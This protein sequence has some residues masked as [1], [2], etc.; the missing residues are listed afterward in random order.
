MADP[1]T[2]VGATA[3]VVQLIEFTSKVL[4]R[5]NEY[6]AKAGELP[7][8]F[9]H[10]AS[11]LPLLRQILEKTQEGINLQTISHEDAEAI[12]PC[13]QG[14]Q[15]QMQKLDTLLLTMLPEAQDRTAKKLAKGLRSLWKDS[16]V[17]KIGAEIDF[18]VA[19]LNFYCSWSSSKLDPRNQDL[20]VTIQQRLAPPDP[21][22]N[23]HK[24]LKL[25]SAKTG[26]WYLQ[27]AQFQAYKTQSSY[28]GWLH[29]SAG[30]GKTILSASI[31]DSLQQ[32]CSKDP[33]RS[34]AFCFFDFNDAAK[35]DAN[36]MVKSLLSQFLE[37]CTRIPSTAQCL[38]TTTSEKQLLDALK[39]TI[40]ALPVLFVVLDALDECNNRER[41]FEILKQIQSWGNKSLHMLVTS[42]KEV[43]IEDALED[44]VLSENMTCLE[45]HLVD[46][47]VRIYVHERLTEDKSFRRW[48]GDPEIQEEIEQTLGKQA[49]GMF[50]WAACQLDTLAHCLTRG[51]VRRALRDL[52]RTLYDTYDRMIRTI[53]ESQNGEEA[54]KI[55]RWLA[56]SR[57]PLSA[58]ELLEVTGIVLEDDDPRF[59]KDEVLQDLRDILRICLSLVSIVP[60][61]QDSDG[62]GDESETGDFLSASSDAS[63]RLKGEYIRL[64]HFSV[65]EYLV[66]A[67]PCIQDFSLPEKESNDILA[68]CCL[69][70]L[71]R[72]E[73]EE[74]RDPDC[75]AKFPLARYAAFY[76][77]KHARVSDFLSQRQRD[78]C[79]KLLTERTP[80]YKAWHRFY[81]MSRRWYEACGLLGEI[82]EFPDPLFSASGEGL[83]HAV[84]AILD[85]G[86]VDTDAMW[87]RRGSALCEASR[88]GYARIVEMLLAKGA[89]PNA[90]KHQ[91][92]LALVQATY[93]GHKK[94]V[95]M[96]LAAGAEVHAEQSPYD[97]AVDVAS[98]SGDKELME[99]LLAKDV[100]S[101]ATKKGC[102]RALIL[103]SSWGRDELVDMLLTSGAN[104]NAEGPSGNTALTA[105][106]GRSHVRTVEIL[107]ANGA[108]V[109][110]QGGLYG[111]ALCY[112]VIHSFL[113]SKAAE[114]IVEMLLAHGADVEARGEERITPLQQA[115]YKGYTK[116]VQMLLAHGADVNALP[117]LNGSALK[118]ASIGGH[119]EIIQI[120]Q[121]EG[122]K[123]WE[124]EREEFLKW[125]HCLDSLS[126]TSSGGSIVVEPCPPDHDEL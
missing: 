115:S 35:Q 95:G 10:I 18:F 42:R 59:D 51:K 73:G 15:Q 2:I 80:A 111:T 5:L 4:T 120:L 16:D 67:R 23:L 33:A 75:E 105:A 29:G 9:A 122:A 63:I 13:L 90:Q 91:G 12:K 64:A 7:S 28:F 85:D 17:D 116:I 98:I 6:R 94:I 78:F 34:L 77:T 53:E 52:P 39:A 22:V 44:L 60:A 1:L 62:S 124:G 31:I 104:I 106:S 81:D 97:T 38:S 41:L 92:S 36:S 37:K 83:L 46:R 72:F 70:Y 26:E 121:A 93:H 48:Q 113:D 88:M 54:L 20:L 117:G 19:R 58:E 123:M 119:Q 47:D 24:A 8:A 65:K 112:A 40:E 87:R 61:A 100:H 21:F 76:W 101:E 71:L 102:V 68:T 11:Q 27:G 43:E 66:S 108:D 109:N 3:S 99:M 30:S 56:Y 86:K 84:Q 57:R 32:F 107:L 96:L 55:L 125:G 45:S 49:C 74:W 82:H 103:A 89:D 110:L 114:K 126:E 118:A 50:R 69:V 25:R 14:C 79:M